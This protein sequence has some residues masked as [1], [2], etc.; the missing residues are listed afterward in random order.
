MLIGCVSNP[1][2]YYLC[3]YESVFNFLLKGRYPVGFSKDQKRSFRRKARGNYKVEGGVLQWG[4]GG[5][6]GGGICPRAPVEA[7]RRQDV[8]KKKIKLSNKNKQADKL[9]MSCRLR[10]C[11]NR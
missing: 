5:G 9:M 3:Y 1:S 4:G 10:N 8:I 6:G 2:I 7:G 11:R